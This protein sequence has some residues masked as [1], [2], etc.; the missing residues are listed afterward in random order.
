LFIR[1]QVYYFISQQ[2][3]ELYPVFIWL[4]LPIEI[5]GNVSDLVAVFIDQNVIPFVGVK[6]F[7]SPWI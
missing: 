2:L 5:S 4:R 3:L 7:D 1:E 6:E